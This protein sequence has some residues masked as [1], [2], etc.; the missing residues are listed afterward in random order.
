MY[1]FETKPTGAALAGLLREGQLLAATERQARGLTGV[2][3]GIPVTGGAFAPAATCLPLYQEPTVQPS[4]GGVAPDSP[5]GAASSS[6]RPPRMAGVSGSWVLDEPGPE[7]VVGQEVVLPG[8]AVDF[9]GRAFV[10]IKGEIRS[11]TLLPHGTDIDQWILSRAARLM[12]ADPRVAARPP[13]GRPPTLAEAVERMQPGPPSF[14]ELKGPA[15][16]AESVSSVVQRTA[17]GGFMAYHDRWV[18]ESKIDLTN[19]SRHEHRLLCRALHLAATVDGLN[20]RGLVTLEYLNRPRLL[21]EEAHRDDVS[22]PSFES[23]HLYMGEEEEL[24][25]A[26][27][28]SSL[29]AHIASELGKEAAILKERRNAREARGPPGKKHAGGKELGAP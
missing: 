2:A 21:L 20:L 12:E 17:G 23:A 25:G 13:P 9:G 10:S 7:G 14:P 19:R 24:P 4:A 18:V 3:A 15:T 27:M 8:A 5:G 22:R 11:V 6:V 1:S 16:L 28:S 29:R 26:A